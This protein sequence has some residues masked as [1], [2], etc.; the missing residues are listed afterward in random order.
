MNTG[1][2]YTSSVTLAPLYKEPPD[3]NFTV[4][5][6]TVCSVDVTGCHIRTICYSNNVELLYV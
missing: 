1:H 6:T 4:T 3:N 5:E 2:C